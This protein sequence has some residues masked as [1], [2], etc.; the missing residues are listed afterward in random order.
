M[1]IRNSELQNGMILHTILEG[2]VTGSQLIPYYR[3]MIKSGKMEKYYLEL[4]DGMKVEK[5]L[6]TDADQDNLSAFL[7]KH[8]SGIV[9]QIEK[10]SQGIVDLKAIARHLPNT[11]VN[12]NCCPEVSEILGLNRNCR[13]AQPC[14]DPQKLLQ[15]LQR[16]MF[17]ISQTKLAM[18]AEKDEAFAIF[19]LWEARSSKL[20]YP[21]KAFRSISAGAAWLL[22]KR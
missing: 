6:V 10:L 16:H 17:N 19:K 8:F 11:I 2:E 3:A 22:E 13:I 9:A 7:K 5:F 18:C 21:V 15:L 14:D 1:T 4:I 12:G 20:G